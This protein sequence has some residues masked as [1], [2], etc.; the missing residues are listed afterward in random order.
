LQETIILEDVFLFRP[1][2][3]A[4]QGAIAF[5]FGGILALGEKD[6]V[7]AKAGK[8]ARVI[9][10]SGGL[11]LPGICDGHTHMLSG[12]LQ[13]TRVDLR[14]VKDREEFSAKIGA[15]ADENP[16]LPWILGEWADTFL[17]GDLPARQ[18][19]DDVSRGKPL[20]L[21]RFD[22]HSALA[23]TRALEIAGVSKRSPDPSGGKIVRDP[24]TSEATGLLLEKAMDLVAVRIPPMPDAERARA[25]QKS[26]RLA[27]GLGIT[28]VH[29]VI[30]HWRDLDVYRSALG[31]E[32]GLK[33]FA[34][35]PFRELDRLL[36]GLEEE[37]SGRLVLDGVKG[38]V[39][40]S[41]GSGTAWL[42]E[43]YAHDPG[44]SGISCV[45]D[46]KKFRAEMKR[47]ARAGVSV[48][49]HAIGDRA[50]GFTLDLFDEIIRDGEG[51]A[52]L[53]IE[54]FQHPG[55]K[56][57][58][59]TGHPR[60]FASIQPAHLLDDAGPAEVRLG[61]ER[62]A[63]SYPVKSLLER[64]CPVVFGSDWDVADLNPLVGLQAAVTRV[65][66]AGRFP[67]GW[68][69]E[70]RVSITRAVE[71]YTSTA[72]RA[73]RV[74]QKLGRLEEGMQ[75]D[76]TVLDRNI[77]SIPAEEISRARAIMTVISGTVV[78]Q[79]VLT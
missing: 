34:R 42:E 6:A 58:E 33:V 16:S 24:R 22:M 37:P 60:L 63:L 29:D 66:K 73:T 70:E 5:D 51:G 65:D 53:R 57:I 64:N 8:R 52:P 9:S 21:T 2:Q 36:S 55:K 48:S 49:I 23:N 4:R 3:K 75:A 46:P 27:Q 19:V 20:F 39:D 54:H 61:P 26:F 17:G 69:P 28:Q 78:H 14:S 50:I 74:S 68:H 12:A 59:R 32:P 79:G 45:E 72:V 71:C 38:F 47:A 43:P 40:G 10:L 62:A 31:K 15:W 56:Q 35:V 18:W 77:T 67:G 30:S 25:L 44:S 13:L 1:D 7:R 11:V 76:L 41:L